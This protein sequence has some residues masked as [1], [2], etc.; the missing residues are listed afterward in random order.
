MTKRRREG[1]QETSRRPGIHEGRLLSCRAGVQMSYWSH[2]LILM[3][4]SSSHTNL[5]LFTGLLVSWSHTALLIFYWS[6]L[7]SLIFLVFL[8]S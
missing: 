3:S 5:L 1:D 7:P 4:W 2:G 6:P 8:F